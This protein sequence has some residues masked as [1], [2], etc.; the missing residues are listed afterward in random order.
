VLVA[1]AGCRQGLNAGRSAQ[2]VGEATT[3]AVVQAIVWM[4]VAASL[5]TV[6][7]QRLGV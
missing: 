7:F 4:V 6:I 1:L 3:A 5:L 2:A